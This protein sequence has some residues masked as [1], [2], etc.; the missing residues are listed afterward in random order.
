MNFDSPRPFPYEMYVG[1]GARNYRYHALEPDLNPY[2]YR[3]TLALNYGMPSYFAKPEEDAKTGRNLEGIT[4]GLTLAKWTD[5]IGTFLGAKKGFL[6]A[7]IK[8][9]LAQIEEREQLL[10]NHLRGIQTET[11]ENSARLL[12]VNR[13]QRGFHPNLDRVRSQ[14]ERLEAGF[15]QEKRM[16]EV[17]NWR[18]ISRLKTEM[19]ELAQE[20]GMEKQKEMLLSDESPK[21][22]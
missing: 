15:E 22:I 5:P 11:L 10:Q 4:D 18:D 3:Y 8:D 16:E 17:A 6:E 2:S 12:E 9:L 19:R 1:I 21:D 13:W 7:S 14:L 20:W